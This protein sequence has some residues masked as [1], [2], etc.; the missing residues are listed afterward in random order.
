MNKQELDNI[1]TTLDT[2]PT[3]KT[4]GR[5][6]KQAG[7]SFELN[8]AKDLHNA[9]FPNVITTRLGSRLLDSQKIDLMNKDEHIH[10]RLPYNIQCKSLAKHA[11][12]CKIL[13]EMPANTAEI[14]VVIHRKTKKSDAGRFIK[15]GTYAIMNADD[16]YTMIAQI[17]ARKL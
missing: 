14:N 2:Q 17:E 5:R 11:D 15:Q 16:F 12:Y 4:N 3:K 10:G 8:V 6:N 9:G 1:I 7:N 13:A